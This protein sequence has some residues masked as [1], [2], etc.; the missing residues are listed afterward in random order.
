MNAMEGCKVVTCNIPGAF[1]QSDWPEDDDCYIKFEGLMVDMLCRIDPT[2]KKKIL[3]TRDGKRKYLYGK[4]T[5]AVYG[6]LLGSII[7]CNKL[8][9]QLEDWGFEKNPYDKC[10]WNKTVDGK[11]FTV[12]AHID[13]L[14]AAHKD[15]C[16]L[17]IISSGNLTES[18]VK[19]RN[20][21]KQRVTYMNI[22]V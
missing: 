6:T 18:L 22:W 3:Y 20:F 8:L 19:K 5:K 17:D 21:K 11:Q 1:L 14:I 7:F 12:Q 4:L 9:K 15:Q 2:Y 16:V 10:T 13:D